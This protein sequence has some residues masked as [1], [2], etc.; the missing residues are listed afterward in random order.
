M[1]EMTVEVMADST[2]WVNR[3][4]EWNMCEGQYIIQCSIQQHQVIQYNPGILGKGYN[5]SFQRWSGF[6]DSVRRSPFT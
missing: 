5:V 1:C 2:M 4:H 3:V 6:S